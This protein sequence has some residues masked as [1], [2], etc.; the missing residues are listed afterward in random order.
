MQET[1]D[2]KTYVN[3][4]NKGD[5]ELNYLLDTVEYLHDSTWTKKIWEPTP[6]LID[7]KGGSSRQYDGQQ[8]DPKLF[9]LVEDGWTHDHCEICQ[10]TIS[11]KEGYGDQAGYAND[12]GDWIC[13]ECYN[14]FIKPDDVQTTIESLGTTER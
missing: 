1:Q 12:N 6:A 10:T 7:K 5:I 11:N 13:L 9:D 8:F 3:I 14:I 4:P 2:K